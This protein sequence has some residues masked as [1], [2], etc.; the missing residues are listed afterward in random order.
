MMLREMMVT[1]LPALVAAS[2]VLIMPLRESANTVSLSSAVIFIRSAYLEEILEACILC[3]FS[4][5]CYDLIGSTRSG[6]PRSSSSSSSS[7][8][9]YAVQFRSLVHIL[10]H[11][12]LRPSV[13]QTER[14]GHPTQIRYLECSFFKPAV[15]SI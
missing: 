5:E 14:S 12:C 1:A 15:G 8:G 10:F 7:I 2:T 6:V 4:M 3:F 9:G 11:E 13:L